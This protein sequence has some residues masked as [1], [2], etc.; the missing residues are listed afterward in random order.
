MSSEDMVKLTNEDIRWMVK[1]VSS[2]YF[3][4]KKASEIYGITERRVQQLTKIYHDTGGGV[5]R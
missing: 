1:R 2:G 5:Q 3:T 4:V